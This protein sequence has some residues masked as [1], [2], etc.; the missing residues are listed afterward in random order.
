MGSDLTDEAFVEAAREMLSR[1]E[2][3][4]LPN[5]LVLS[6]RHRDVW[7]TE[8]GQEL[9]ISMLQ[10]LIEGFDVNDVPLVLAAMDVCVPHLAQQALDLMIMAFFPDGVI[11]DVTNLDDA[12]LLTLAVLIGASG[13]RAEL[14]TFLDRARLGR[15]SYYFQCAVEAIEARYPV[16]AA[17]EGP[18]KAKLIIWDLDDTLWQ[19]TLADGDD[20]VLFDHR[21]DYVRAFNN[22]GIV[23]AICS[24]NDKAKAREKLEAFGLWDE[25]VFRR[26]AFVPKGA[27]IKQIIADMQLRPANVLFI[28]D[29]PHNLH[30]VADAVPGIHVV[31]ATTPECDA[32][33]AQILADNAHVRKSRVADYRLIETKVSEREDNALSD[34]AFLMQSGIEACFVHRMD[35]LEFADRIEELI[36]RSN[37]LNYTESRV[38]PGK[39]HQCIQ[40]M[41]NYVVMSIFVWDKYGYYG[42]VGAAVWAWRTRKL[43]HLAFSCRIMHMGVEDAMIRHLVKMEDYKID[44]AQLRKPLPAQ[45]SAA[46]RIVPYSDPQVRRRI[47]DAEAPRDWSKISLRIMADC[48]SGAFFHYSRFRDVIEHDNN[49]RLF[50]LPMMKTGEYEKQ[51]FPPHLMF[52]AASDYAVWRWHK[53]AP[54]FDLDLYRDCGDRF[55]DMVVSGNRKCLVAL[56]PQDLEIC[57]YMLHRDCDL[58]ATKARHPVLN[59][60]WRE[61]ARRHPDHFTII[62]L[63]DEL[64]GDDLVS[65][66][67]Y[68]PSALKHIAGLIDDWYEDQM[69]RA[70]ARAAA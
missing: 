47:L 22:H 41:D 60:Y 1:G 28:D 43:E 65:A 29:N 37:Q 7:P 15:N 52:A 62:E 54:T 24:K 27:V 57:K 13:Q 61:V 66:H 20:P 17:G 11:G 48:Q 59:D 12:A 31:D 36:N 58:E 70:P 33:L 26:I 25:F 16:E 38:E 6:E 46:I 68:A 21:A 49:P 45:S 30:E 8:T 63:A 53:L 3:S 56:P 35:N 51:D 2:I 67:H 44:P 9:L 34:E 69:S 50:S 42:L 39:I 40:D 10:Q 14:A 64:K 4:L 5:I 18:L 55:V 32:L 19:G 23:S